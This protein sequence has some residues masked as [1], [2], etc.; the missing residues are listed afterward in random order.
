MGLGDIPDWEEPRFI[1][2]AKHGRGWQ[3]PG[4]GATPSA[5]LDSEGALASLPAGDTQQD[6]FFSSFRDGNGFHV[7]P[8]PDLSGRFR[9]T[10]TGGSSSLGGGGISN[11]T[12]INATTW[13]FDCNYIGNKWL[14]FTPT[15][16]PIKVSIVRTTDLARHAAG[17]IFRQEL[18]D[19][20]PTGGTYR[21]MDWM[22]TNNSTVVNLADYPVEASQR[23]NRAP[24]SVMVSLCNAKGADMW[25]NIPHQATDA[26]VTAWA[27][28]IRD[29]L[30]G[31]VNVEYSNEVW[32]TGRFSQGAWLKGQAEAVWGVPDGYGGGGYWMDYA[33]K[34][35]AQC[36]QIFNT[37]FGAQASRVIGIIAGQAANPAISQRMLDAGSWQSFEP[38]SYVRPSTLAK[39]YAIA[40][41]I[42]WTGNATT[43]G[44]NVKAQ[45]DI[46]QAAAVAYI[47]TLFPASVA[48]AK[49][50]IDNA[51][52]IAAS[53][54]LRLNFYE[55]NGHF[56][57]AQAS[58]S[59]LYSGGNPVPGAVE[60][61]LEAHYST[62]MAD[63]QDEI[64]NYSRTNNISLM[65]FFV[66]MNRASRFGTWGAKTHFAHSS[67]IWNDLL[68]WH[69]A[70]PRWWA[71]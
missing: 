17:Q 48:G 39:A 28:Y 38:G 35:F 70:N 1:D 47:K 46:S 25:I 5:N 21:F 27:T 26:L 19:F 2:V 71:R 23:W 18:L 64:R 20:L 8:Q 30:S 49:V 31:K 10:I 33:G 69:T 24:L 40:P 36:M 12:Q 41:Y 54:G 52:P 44:N 7:N 51:I 14:T 61:F 65:A 62:E 37:V 11:I 22:L 59:A 45:L 29:N 63:A 42:G 9:V 56:D 53:R 3:R 67:V 55:F 58:G 6:F 15:A 60:A 68:A 32:N 13:E 43:E 50:A 57:V 4:G 16:F 34:R 66:D